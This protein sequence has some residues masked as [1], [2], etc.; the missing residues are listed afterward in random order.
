VADER[1]MVGD[2]TTN[3]RGDEYRQEEV[4]ASAVAKN[5]RF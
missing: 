1:E 5:L 4:H 2:K 3:K